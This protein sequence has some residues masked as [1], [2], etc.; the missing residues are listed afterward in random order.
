MGQPRKA[1]QGRYQLSNMS[2]INYILLRSQSGG[3]VS[4]ASL[5]ENS[6]LF[7]SPDMRT[8]VKREWYTARAAE[9]HHE[10]EYILEE[11][12]T[13]KTKD[14]FTLIKTDRVQVSGT[15]SEQKFASLSLTEIRTQREGLTGAAAAI[16]FSTAT[17]VRTVKFGD[18]AVQLMD[19][20]GCCE[21]ND[22]LLF[23]LDRC[24][25]L[26]LGDF[27]GCR[28]FKCAAW[29]AGLLNPILLEPVALS[30]KLPH[31]GI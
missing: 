8:Q 1:P 5:V 14:D 12:L 4:T 21:Q 23:A 25:Q 26:Q 16:D 13:K 17:A 2:R 18:T 31:S 7:T 24:D 20:V 27:L 15:V 3:N 30:S 6:V 28:E 19:K 11:V 29:V 9:K 10:A 22:A